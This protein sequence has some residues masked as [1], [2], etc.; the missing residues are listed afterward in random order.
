[1]L[2]FGVALSNHTSI[3]GSAILYSN[4]QDWP[5]EIA[6]AQMQV[7][8]PMPGQFRGGIGM[9]RTET[10]Q[11]QIA[12]LGGVYAL[13]T[14]ATTYTYVSGVYPLALKILLA[15]NESLTVGDTNTTKVNFVTSVAE[16]LNL[17]DAN[18]ALRSLPITLAEALEFSETL[19]LRAIYGIQLPESLLLQDT[20]DTNAAL[21]SYIV[22]SNTN[23]VSTYSNF[24]FNSFI[25]MGN[26]FYGVKS[27]GIFELT[28]ADDDGVQIDAAVKFGKS[29]LGGDQ[30]SLELAKRLPEIYLGISA[31]G[32]MH[33]KVTAS[34]N[35]R[36][37]LLSPVV[38][39]PLHTCR[40]LLGKGVASRYWDLELVNVSGADFT[41]ESITLR[42]EVTVRRILER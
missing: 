41:L 29:G 34:G 40:L 26:K 24:N 7:P 4:E 19:T 36:V 21:V 13:D 9:F 39:A 8:S 3:W 11:P 31:T 20:V 28:G 12:F 33:L 10:G 14:Y 37:Y 25:Q 38:G 6:Q 17:A 1:M 2:H 30:T 18:A 15:L 35:D 42:P 16:T 27:G 32:K 22:N 23:A 5:A